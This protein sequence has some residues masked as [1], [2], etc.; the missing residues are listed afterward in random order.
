VVSDCD[1]RGKNCKATG[2]VAGI[3]EKLAAM[4]NFTYETRLEP[5]GEWGVIGLGTN[6]TLGVFGR[7]LS[8][9]SDLPQDLYT[10]QGNSCRLHSALLIA[11]LP[12]GNK[13]QGDTNGHQPV[14]A[15]I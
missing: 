8:G 7:F 10:R 4:Y 11:T 1:D 13:C 6:H 9:D 5:S 14:H 15:S 12:N 2:I 3:F